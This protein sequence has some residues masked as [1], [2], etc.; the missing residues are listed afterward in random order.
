M[1]RISGDWL[2]RPE[3]RAVFD[4]LE[5]AGH[6]AFFVGGCVR[7]A[8]AGHP[9][10]DIDISTDAR[11]EA[12]M[13]LGE[14]AGMKAVPTGI[15]HGTVTL[16]SGA[17]PHEVTTFRRDVETDG[18][19]AVVAYS[20]DIREDAER[21]D[22]TMNALYAYRNGEVLDPVNTGVDDL[23]AGRV[24]FVGEAEARIREDYL[25]ILRYFRFLARFG[26]AGPDPDTLAAIGANLAGIDTLA[27]ERVGHEVKR[28][29]ALPDPGP[30]V[31]TMATAGVLAR[32]LPG[33]DHRWIPVLIDIEDR[34]GIPADAMRRLA[35][36]GG[37]DPANR[38][39][40]SRTEAKSLHLMRDQL[41]SVAGIPEIA[42]R[43]GRDAAMNV[44]LL[45]GALGGMGLAPDALAEADAGA[46]A[47]FPLRAGDLMPAC[48]GPALGARLKELE[49]RWI[50]SGFQLTKDELLKD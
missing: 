23:H 7:D 33:A 17:I 46:A 42:Y 27:A 41:G 26:S 1:T 50:A 24:V 6:R 48:E 29:L 35:C 10:K 21:R 4:A 8:L 5:G 31:A 36:L 13:A 12:V 28:L 15:D 30:S 49:S 47:R 19:R 34:N 39:R 40:L 32:V 25:R 37:E 38:L 9:V 18:R 44:A 45:R 11:P 3:T 16:V 43:H 2:D 22:F 20:D 14:G